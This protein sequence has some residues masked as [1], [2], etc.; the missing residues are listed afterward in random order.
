MDKHNKHGSKM[1][2]Q[3]GHYPSSGSEYL[4]STRDATTTNNDRS[5]ATIITANEVVCQ[6]FKKVNKP[7]PFFA[8]RYPFL[9]EASY[10]V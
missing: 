8:I 5:I 7:Q 9:T 6:D 10:T 2:T 4:A 3:H 1:L